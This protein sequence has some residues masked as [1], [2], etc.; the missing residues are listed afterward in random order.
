VEALS[1][2]LE[3]PKK[4]FVALMGGAKISDKIKTIDRLLIH[5]DQLL[6]GGAMAYPFLKAQGAEI[7]R[8]LC[9]DSDLDLAKKILQRPSAMKIHLPSDH[10]ITDKFEG[11]EAKLCDR[12][13]IPEDF[14]GMDIGPRTRREY[15]TILKQA[16]TV[17]WNGPMG[18]F[19]Q[20]AYSEG[21]FAMAKAISESEAFSVVGGG[22]SVSAVNQTGLQDRFSHISSGGGAS[23]EFIEQGQLPG[24]QALKFGV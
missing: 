6:I 16:A 4:P 11:G 1:Q 19:E 14:M 10:I 9:T 22:D 7:G 15:T 23:L 24:I 21:T 5:V 2:L 17:F 3:K 18:L 8:S 20:K 12:V 13:S